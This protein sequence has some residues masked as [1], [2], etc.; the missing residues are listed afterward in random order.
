MAQTPNDILAT[1]TDLP[2]NAAASVAD[3][4][5]TSLADSDA[6]YLKTRN[7][8][9]MLVDRTFATIICCSTTAR[10]DR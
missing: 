7:F 10:P 6:L 5:N 2:T 3:A 9:G 1:P 4:L 8:T